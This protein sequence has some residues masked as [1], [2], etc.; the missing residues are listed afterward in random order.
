MCIHCPRTA[1]TCNRAS[2]PGVL[3]D[4]TADATSL[5][6]IS[7]PKAEQEE[8]ITQFLLGR[9]VFVALPTRYGSYF[10]L[11]LIFDRLRIAVNCV[12]CQ[13]PSSTN[14]GPGGSLA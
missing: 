5:L 3:C 14:E 6:G 11:P 1:S 7:T 13:P 9:D 4:K 12:G 2:V 8:A 10:T